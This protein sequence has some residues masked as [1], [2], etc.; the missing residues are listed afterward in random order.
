MYNQLVS[1]TDFIVISEL[2][3]QQQLRLL[4]VISKLASHFDYIEC[5]DNKDTANKINRSQNIQHNF[6]N[7]RE[8]DQAAKKNVAVLT[9]LYGIAGC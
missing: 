6:N 5:E 7:I 1:T 2:W 8:A 3:S 9:L 4:L